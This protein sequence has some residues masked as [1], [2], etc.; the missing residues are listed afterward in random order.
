MPAQASISSKILNYHR[1]RNQD[2]PR[3]NQIYTISFHKSSPTK[4]NRCKTLTQGGKLHPR[5]SKK[6]FFVQQ[7]QKKI[8][9][10][11]I[12]SLRTKITGSNNNWPLIFI[13]INGLNSPIKLSRLTDWINK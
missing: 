9:T 11:S 8:A 7:T 6:V 12:L 13:N 2:I 10:Q 4:D 1:W 5:K 3:Q